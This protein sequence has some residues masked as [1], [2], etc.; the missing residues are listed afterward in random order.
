MILQLCT[1]IRRLV[2]DGKAPS[3]VTKSDRPFLASKVKR[4]GA[5]LNDQCSTKCERT[6]SGAISSVKSDTTRAIRVTKASGNP[7]RQT[8][9]WVASHGVG[10]EEKPQVEGMQRPA[11]GNQGNGGHL[12][13]MA[14]IEHVQ[15]TKC[16]Q[17]KANPALESQPVNVLV[18]QPAKHRFKPQTCV[19]FSLVAESE[20]G[21]DMG[22]LH[23]LPGVKP[24]KDRNGNREHEDG[25]G[26]GEHEDRDDNGNTRTGMTM[27]NMR[28]RTVPI[29]TMTMKM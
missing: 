22:L 1:R 26:D 19:Q 21:D 3:F 5:V 17:K 18:P 9:L 4:G 14:N 27:G 20:A 25:Y 13:Q 8:P 24:G 6:I 10:Q 15:T 12:Q 29:M 16:P 28:T 23:Q 11:H 7:S 2:S